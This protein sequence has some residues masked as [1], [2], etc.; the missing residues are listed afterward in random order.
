MDVGG[1][2]QNRKFTC[3]ALTGGAD[4]SLDQIPRGVLQGGDTAEVIYGGRTYFYTFNASSSTA[5][6]S[7]GVIKSDSSAKNGRWILSG[8]SY[9]PQAATAFTAQDATPSVA[10]GFKFKTANASGTTITT[11]DDGFEGQEIWVLLDANTTIDF[12][13]SASMVGNGGSDWVCAADDFLTATKEGAKWY[14]TVNN[15]T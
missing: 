9:K 13:S 4:G 1:Y 15:A 3:T 7:P 14:C 12:S 2:I 6:S 11:F 5:E 10:N 8:I